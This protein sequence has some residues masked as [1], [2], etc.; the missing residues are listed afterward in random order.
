MNKFQIKQKK[1]ITEQFLIRIVYCFV[2][3]NA[4][5]LVIY[6]VTYG[7]QKMYGEL[8]TFKHLLIFFLLTIPF[9][10]IYA[11]TIEKFGSGFGIILSGWTSKKI[12]PREQLSA[13]LAN[14]RHSKIN[15]RFEESLNIINNVLNKDENFPEALYLKAQVLWEGFGRSVESKKLF[16]RV[17]QLLSAEEPLHRWSSDYIEKITLRDKMRVDEFMEG[18]EK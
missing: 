6:I 8:F 14:A 18:K 1:E 15:N 17:M 16:R 11:Y 12:S 10:V 3:S 13:D 5:L 4:A 2:W 7:F 9:S